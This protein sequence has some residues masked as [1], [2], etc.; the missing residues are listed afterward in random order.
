MLVYCLFDF[1]LYSFKQLKQ[2]FMKKISTFL[3]AA[4]LS[5]AA[6]GQDDLR[7]KTDSAEKKIPLLLEYSLLDLPFNSYG[8][9]T[10]ENGISTENKKASGTFSDAFRFRSPEQAV[11][12]HNDV[13]GA[14][15]WGIYKIP[16]FRNKPKLNFVIKFLATGTFDYLMN[17]VPFGGGW[18]HEEGHRAV[19]ATSYVSSYNP[20]AFKK[21]QDASGGGL[22]AV[23]YVLDTN[24]VMMKR[25][26]NANFVRMS[27]MGG[28]M[29]VYSV[30]KMQQTSFFNYPAGHHLNDAR[31]INSAKYILDLANLVGYILTCGDKAESAKSTLEQIGREGPNQQLRDFTGLDF[32]A[33]A[34][35][36]A[37]PN[38]PY[39]KRGLNPY[40]NGYDRYIYGDKLT[41]EEYKWIA[42]Q[43]ALS[44]IN[45]LSPMVFLV[46]KINIGKGRGFNF[47]GRYYPTSFGAQTGLELYYQTDK[48]N[49][50]LAPHLNNNKSN[51]FFGLEAMLYEQP[52]SLLGMDFLGTLRV[53]ADL[54]PKNQLFNT[55]S[56]SFTGL[57][58]GRLSWKAGKHFY[59]YLAL[60]AKNRGWIAG[61]AFLDGNIS[62]KLGLSA[63]FN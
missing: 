29:T 38:E 11:Q 58:G 28:E 57:L 26:D 42:K 5:V 17:Q 45:F 19:M 55:G 6:Y 59:P 41:S 61:N 14:G 12:L 34:Y 25:D 49:I 8:A 9:R 22:S 27:T 31:P 23:S 1:Y 52:L 32:T 35:D 15:H 37:R 46:D 44:Y 48:Y 47:S 24:L 60:D 39:A 3:L 2:M 62:V 16:L 63:R 51:S 36:L 50:F 33:W 18:V 56:S 30:L 13:M 20:F 40:G 54:Q 43:G 53:I 21:K 7:E 10:V 4:A